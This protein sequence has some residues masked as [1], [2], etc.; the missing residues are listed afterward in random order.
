M[1]SFEIVTIAAASS[2]FGFN[3]SS[4]GPG[5]GILVAVLS[6]SVLGSLHCVGMCGGFVAFYSAG[7]GGKG[8]DAKGL[9][10]LAYHGGRL[11]GYAALGAVAGSVGAAVDLA[12]GAVGVGRVA[13]VVAGSVMV[14]W[15]LALLLSTAGVPL[16][17]W[18]FVRVVEQRVA[19]MLASLASRPPVIRAGLL[20]LASGLLPCGWLYAFAVTA[21][22]TGS[23][24]WG[25]AVM[26]T[27]WM[28]SVPVLLGLGIGVQGIAGRL[29]RHIP[30]LSA[31]LLVGIGL[32]GVLGR[33]N[34]PA[35]ALHTVRGA[36]SGEPPPCHHDAH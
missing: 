17:K 18:R 24:V 7:G 11:L 14:L 23:A 27:F 30:T 36:L 19:P 25:A 21:A 5:V 10:H 12:G 1:P 28:G 35:F 20:G 32:V 34:I 26:A 29:R 8:L 15:G 33:S 16:P 2:L 31:L 13:A 22:G 9:A 3:V 6:A 4:P